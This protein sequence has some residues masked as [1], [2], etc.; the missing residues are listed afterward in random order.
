MKKLFIVAVSLLI[1]FGPELH[2]LAVD[3]PTQVIVVSSD[4]IPPSEP[5]PPSEVPAIVINEILADPQELD[6]ENEF[7]ELYN[8]GAET[9]DLYGWQLDDARADDGSFYFESN[10]LLEPGAYLVLFRPQTDIT[11]NND[12][13]SVILFNSKG[14]EVDRFDFTSQGSGR[15]WGRHPSNIE[16][17][18]VFKNPTPGFVNE[19]EVNALPVAV[20]EV[21]KDTR[22]M[23]L[24][25]TGA[26]SYDP[27]GDKLTFMWEFEE[28]S[29]DQRENPLIYTYQ[30]PGEKVIRLTVTDSLGDSG[31]AEMLFFAAEEDTEEETQ[32]EVFPVYAL[33]S[34]VMPSPV[35]V[36]D[37]NEWIELYNEHSFGID[38]SGWYLD[39]DEGK[40]SPYKIPDGTVIYRN[41]YMVFSEPGLGLSFKNSDDVVRILD[42]NKNVNQAI[43]YF[44]AREGW[45][46]ARQSFDV[47]EWTPLF[48][49][50]LPNKFPPPPISY[51]FGDIVFEAVLPNP[52]G[53][54]SGNEQIVLKN[55]LDEEVDLTGWTMVD[56]GGAEKSLSE[57]VIPVGGNLTMLSSEFKLSLNNSDESLSL[58]DATGGLI[59]E[60]RWQTS[61]S[62]QWLFNPNSF[63]NGMEVKVVRVIDGDTFVIDLNE[64]QFTVRMIG[65]DTPETVHPFKPIEYYGR[66]A[67]DFL[68]SILSGQW[69]TLE[70]DANKIDKYG[71]VLAYVYWG[72]EMINERIL[73]E[74]YGYAYTR[75]PFQFLKEFLA[76]EAEARQA[77]IGLW[78]NQKVESIIN[79]IISMELLTEEEELPEELLLPLIE[80]GVLSEEETEIVGEVLVLPDCSSEYLKIDSFLPNPQKGEEVEYI[81]LINIGSDNICLSGWMLDDV[82][83]GGSKPFSIRGGSIAS[84]GMRTFRKQETKLALNNSDDCVHLIDPKGNVAD[85]ICYKK[86]HKNEIFTHAGGDWVPKPKSKK[87]KVS[88]VTLRHKFKRDFISY[89]SDLL[90]NSYVGKVVSF[91][92]ATEVMVMEL[93][94]GRH[95]HISYAGSPV[96]MALAKELIDFS[97]PVK[98]QV[99]ESGDLITLLSIEPFH[100]FTQISRNEA[101]VGIWIW[102]LILLM[103]LPLLMFLRKRG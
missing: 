48:T 68:K 85:Q 77:G 56:A 54:D 58:F 75:F 7:I 34:E 23:K 89:Q 39:D 55:T 17:W 103:P 8:A 57:Q 93:E 70:F 90:T 33:F 82:I 96:N 16:E 61:S 80:E 11:L 60:I 26:G 50:E 63:K 30:T 51:N 74:G 69:V 95:I 41:S 3:V 52:E 62:G 20:I 99:Y 101:G 9:I 100:F 10:C 44:E 79:E 24:N 29:Y 86:T 78:E 84:G 43:H 42:P 2:V 87:T 18:L 37:E 14:Y 73:K 59:D 5:I 28:G 102:L 88:N 72:D 91:G 83:Q 97:E 67:A 45:S 35:G 4:D 15:S 36:D 66:Q 12:S 49:P 19:L 53:E 22:R 65:I 38:L 25:V 94:A 6:A 64:K 27:D 13:D 1:F 32:L 76:L 31:Q 46:F 98:V 81:R 71:R 47:F 21:Q 40:S 92:E